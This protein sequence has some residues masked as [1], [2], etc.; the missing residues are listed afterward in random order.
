MTVRARAAALLCLL[1]AACGRQTPEQRMDHV[2]QARADTGRFSGAVLVARDG[3]VLLSQ[4]YGQASREW[5]VPNTPATRFRLASI[6]KQ[7]T[8]AA[9]LQFAERGT[10]D[11]DAPLKTYFPEAPPAWDP[12]TVLQL[13]NH[14]SGIPDYLGAPDYAATQALPATPQQLL[15]RFRD[16]PLDFPPGTRWAYSNSGYVLLGLLLE[17]LGGMSYGEV[18]HQNLFAPLGLRDT[19]CDDGRKPV[20]HLASGYR[21]DQGAIVPALFRHQSTLYAAGGLYSTTTDLLRWEQALYGGKVLSAASLAKMTTPGLQQSGLGLLVLPLEDHVVYA[22]GGGVDGVHT[23]M[24]YDP[25]LRTTVIVL[26]N[27][28]DADVVDLAG[29]LAALARGEQVILPAERR[30]RT[31]PPGRLARFAGSYELAPG[32]D[33]VFTVENGALMGQASGQQKYPAA[34][35]APDMFFFPVNGAEVEFFGE[36]VAAGSLVLHQ[37]GQ[38]FKARRKP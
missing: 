22:H 6:S 16:R 18:L 32:F 34:A 29:E 14:S 27:L 3:Q 15:A 36:G 7:F 13:L 2:V 11:L 30:E 19:G 20:P 4:G 26:A 17:K 38:Y 8:A 33:L 35:E 24:V 37:N 31:L 1:A 23:M 12:V 10:L 25:T 9:I 21:L 5:E 28:Q